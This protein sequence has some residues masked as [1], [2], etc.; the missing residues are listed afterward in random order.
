M[1]REKDTF[2]GAFGELLKLKLRAGAGCSCS[3][4]WAGSEDAGLSWGL[5]A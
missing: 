5:W 3:I 1:A 4:A 2:H